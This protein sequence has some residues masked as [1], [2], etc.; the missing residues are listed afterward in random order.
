MHDQHGPYVGRERIVDLEAVSQK[1]VTN[2]LQRTLNM[3]SSYY[4]FATMFGFIPFLYR[5]RFG[6]AWR[7]VTTFL[8]AL[9][10]DKGATLPV[11]IAGFCWD[12]LHGVKLSQ[13]NAD[14]KLADGR[15]LADA[16]FVAHPCNL[17]IPQDITDVKGSLSIAIGDDD[18]VMPIKQVEAA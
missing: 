9:R 2:I 16:F 17:T 8:K 6:V 1:N 14:T 11:G 10:E 12:G 3:F 7:R 15:P 5:N 4:T 13:D 18:G